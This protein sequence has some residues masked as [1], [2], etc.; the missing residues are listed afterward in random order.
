[1]EEY[2]SK[3]D[4]SWYHHACNDLEIWQDGMGRWLYDV[5]N[6]RH[7]LLSG[8]TSWISFEETEVEAIMR[9]RLR[10]VFEGNL[11]SE[12]DIRCSI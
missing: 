5:R 10:V 7:K 4:N 2:G 12:I 3:Q 1:M 11:M 6:V 8:D 9:W